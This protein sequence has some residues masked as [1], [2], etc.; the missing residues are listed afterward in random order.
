MGQKV[1]PIGLPHGRDAG[2]EEPLVRLQEGVFAGLLLED[3]KIRN[4]IKNHPKSP[5]PHTRASTASK[6]SGR[7]TKSKSS[8]TSPA[9]AIDHRQEGPGQSNC[10]RMELQN[11]IGR[12][13]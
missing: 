12:R 11:L 10:C 8:C 6:S 2:L 13:M 4:F 3:Q 7:A 9:P 1:N 5:V